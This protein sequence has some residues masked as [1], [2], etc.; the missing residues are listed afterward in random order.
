[1]F[2]NTQS[3]KGTT[4]QPSK[5]NKVLVYNLLALHNNPTG[6]QRYFRGSFPSK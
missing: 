2:G 5:D 6:G 3:L 4:S 1:M